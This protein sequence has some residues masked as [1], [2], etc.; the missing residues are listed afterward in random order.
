M[1]GSGV[2]LLYKGDIYSTSGYAR[3]VRNN[4]RALD[5]AGVQLRI[6]SVRHDNITTDFDTY[7]N[8]NVARL[9]EPQIGT[10][11]IRITQQTPDLF[12]ID[13]NH[14]EIGYTVFETSH[15]P[16]VD[17]DGIETKNWV[18]QLNRCNEVWTAS[19]FCRQMFID[20]GVKVPVFAY[21]HPID[22]NVYT[23]GAR[24]P[25]Y[26]GGEEVN[27]DKMVFLSVFQWNKRKDPHAL[28]LAWWAEF[29]NN[30]EVQLVIKT[31]GTDFATNDPIVDA[32][33]RFRKDCGV[34]EHCGNVH[35]LTSQVGEHEMSQVY[36]SCDVFVSATKG[37]G[38][39]LPFQEAQ[40]CGLPSIYPYA[41]ALPEF[42]TGWSVGTIREPAHGVNNGW[43]TIDMDWWSINMESM[44]L[45]LRQAYET[46]KHNRPAF[47]VLKSAAR[48]RVEAHSFEAIGNNMATRL[49]E[50]TKQLSKK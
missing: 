11:K 14:Y 21:A 26:V 38:F 34:R 49:Q 47:N 43:Y 32:I 37:E 24:T 16:N 44:R 35:I 40:A 27:K 19:S 33:R 12:D 17:L 23:P 9:L 50:V 29:R 46:W 13:P 41:T 10:P 8:K 15:I 36:R 31:Y 1:I 2:S 18:K 4:I 7:W 22:L 5:E 6:Q 42:C 48:K 28:L 25:F 45:A 3:A 39:G 30:P 20:S